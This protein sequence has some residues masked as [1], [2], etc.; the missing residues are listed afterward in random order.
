MQIR[1]DRTVNSF[2]VWVRTWDGVV[3]L[4]GW[5][6]TPLARQQAGIIAMNTPGVKR[7]NN[8]IRIWREDD[9]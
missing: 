5:V 9:Y 2:R 4:T 3:T 6:D 7:V 1:E 8:N